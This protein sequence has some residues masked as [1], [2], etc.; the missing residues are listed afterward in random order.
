MRNRKNTK[1]IK[2]SNKLRLETVGIPPLNG[3]S[4]AIDGTEGCKKRASHKRPSFKKIF[5]FLLI[6][7]TLSFAGTTGKISGRVV[8]QT[9]R[10]PMAGVNII[11]SGTNLGAATDMNGEY[12]I[13]NLP[14]GVYELR[15]SMIGYQELTIKNISVSVDLTT[16]IDLN[17][18]A[19]VLEGEAVSIVAQSPPIQKDLTAKMVI[20]DGQTISEKLPVTHIKEVLRAQGGIIDD[21]QGN[22]HIRG[23]RTGELAWLVDGVLVKDV[24][25]GGFGSSV[26]L[27]CIRELNILTGG[28]NA[29]YGEAMSGVINIT[30]KEGGERPHFRFQYETPM[31]NNSPYHK[32]DWKV[33]S[34]NAQSF[35]NPLESFR[36]AVRD[37]T[38]K[39]VYQYVSVLDTKY[40]S[41]IPLNL[42][43][44]FS[45]SMSGKVLRIPN[46]YFFI[47]GENQ[48]ENSPLPW[49]FDLNKRLFTKLTF[50]PFPYLKLN[51][52]Y[53]IQWNLE[54]EYDHL[55]KYYHYYKTQNKGEQPVTQT[56]SNFLKLS[57]THTLNKST[58][59]DFHLSWLKREQKHEIENR[60]VEFDPETGDFINSDYIKRAFIFGR[61]YDFWYGDDR[62][63]YH[64]CT[65]TLNSK[66]DLTSQ[67]H[68]RHQIKLGVDFKRHNI[69]QHRIQR[70][71]PAAF[72][73]RIEFYEKQPFEGAAYIQDKMEYDFMILNVGLRLDYMNYN[74]TFWE[75]TGEIQY[76]DEANQFRFAPQTKVPNRLQLSPR[77]G[78]SHPVTENLLFY[79]S[80]GHFFQ[81]PNYEILFKNDTFLNNLK[82][83]DPIL[84]NPGLKPQQ[85]IAF[86]TGGKMEISPKFII[87]VTGFYRDMRNL[88]TTQYYARAPFD[89]TIYENLDYGRTK[90]IEL[91]IERKFNNYFT[92][93][94]NYTFMQAKGSGNDPLTG[95]YYREEDAHLRPKR[96]IYL[97]FDRTHSLTFNFDLRIQDDC[98]VELMGIH[99]FENMAANLLYTAE[100][101][102]PYTP[103]SRVESISDIEPNS[104]RMGWLGQLD[105]RV[106]KRFN[107][108]SI[109]HV[110]YIKIKNLFDQI[111]PRYVW[112]ETGLPWDGGPATQLSKDRQA[113]P[114]NVGPRRE[115]RLGYFFQF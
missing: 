34:S 52:N 32:A 68:N 70:P 78:L 38:G 88:V 45:F 97:D 23:G 74:D 22:L 20:L 21:G 57:V 73:H 98:G 14:P 3:K 40:K 87:D 90:G 59:Y 13:N 102:L 50:K 69:F 110:I 54:Q 95:Y 12:F 113:D 80:Y 33:S 114:T 28:F 51:L 101:G 37:S 77:I 47:S 15:A 79:F 39:S 94:F 92:S 93:S 64:N 105:L 61:E 75:N 82:E 76:L 84:G 36:D 91:N 43:G 35:E 99:P 85:T 2:I 16:R 25:N 17:L 19:T 42:L 100:S 65:E 4:S 66:F 11:I 89:Y 62:D 46:S 55:Y 27:N 8:D 81:S 44:N 107:F 30:T 31:L 112:A 6:P 7:A 56:Q 71:W 58:F 104:E 1:F 24:L 49:G 63:W 83:S 72:Y 18:P 108:K 53:Q 5:L 60:T 29:E 111:N 96:E 86:E 10:S 41:N 109:N 26:D 103:I 9:S 67:I 48:N 115:I 106:E